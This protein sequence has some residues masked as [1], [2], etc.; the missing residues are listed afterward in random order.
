MGTG[1]S[2]AWRAYLEEDNQLLAVAIELIQACVAANIDWFV[3]NPA[4]R[5]DAQSPAYW[6]EYEHLG[7]LW[8]M[9]I[10]LG[11][12]PARLLPGTCPQLAL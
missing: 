3:E 11:L 9:L 5:W 4:P 2:E 1:L 8:D 7:T 12:A 6:D 10:P